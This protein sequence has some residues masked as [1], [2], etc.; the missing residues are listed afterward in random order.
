M[1]STLIMLP[2]SG[3]PYIINDNYKVKDKNALAEVQKAVGGFIQTVAQP[4]DRVIIHHQEIPAWKQV[5]KL[6]QKA[7]KNALTIYCNENGIRECS[8]N[9]SVFVK[10]WSGQPQQLMGNIVI[11]IKNKCFNKN[12]YTAIHASEEAMNSSALTA[13]QL[14][15]MSSKTFIKNTQELTATLLA[16][17]NN[18]I[19]FTTRIVKLYTKAIHDLFDESPY[20]SDETKEKLLQTVDGDWWIKKL[21]NDMKK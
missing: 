11:K 6:I 4:R 12:K 19:G 3:Q 7:R 20:I 2:V 14:Y 13:T 21:Q 1:S 9:I 15:L 17:S 8:P 10:N 18:N 16:K 5:N